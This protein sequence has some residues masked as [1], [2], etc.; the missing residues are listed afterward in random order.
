M[1]RIETRRANGAA[2]ALAGLALIAGC[3]GQPGAPSGS[4]TAQPPAN[5]PQ[6]TLALDRTFTSVLYGY[7]IDHPRNFDERPATVPLRGTDPPLFGE[8]IVDRLETS[9]AGAMVLASAELPDSVAD[10]AAWTAATARAFCG[11]PTASEQITVGGAAATLDTFAS[12][13][14]YFHL[15]LT[16]VRDGR[17]YHVVWLNEPGTEVAD[18]GLFLA[19]LDTFEFGQPAASA[20]ATSSRVPAGMRPIEPGD[21][22]PDALLG[23]WSH[24]SGGFMWFLRAGEP[25]CLQRPRTV[26]DCALWQSAGRPVE[27]AIV[28]VV[29]G[30]LQVQWTQGGCA[31]RAIYSFGIGEDRLTMRLV[32]GCQS[33]D[34]VLA[35][36]G[37]AGA[38]T[39]PPKPGG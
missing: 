6:P 36:T 23:A 8:P 17:G 24:P 1:Q 10:L 30:R 31:G 33:G 37:S 20:A 22:I 16:M 2:A 25:A 28:A 35:R 4:A 26:Q 5:S 21:P 39:A 3:V 12:C 18:R 13:Q 32:G 11:T 9:S 15:W 27:S 19:I 29:D 38:P 14:G 7:S 34:F